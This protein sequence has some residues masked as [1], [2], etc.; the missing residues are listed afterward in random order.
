MIFA[1]EKQNQTTLACNLRSPI[2]M[3]RFNY[4]VIP[5]YIFAIGY[6]V[7]ARKSPCD[8]SAN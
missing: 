3:L 2:S 4:K 8:E 1:S 5:L 7:W 6:I